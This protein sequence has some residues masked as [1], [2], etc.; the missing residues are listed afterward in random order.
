MHELIAIGYWREEEG[1]GASFPEPQML[2]TDAY[3]PATREAI[4]R[5]LDSGAVFMEYLGFSFCRFRC[6]IPDTA[7]GTADLSDGHWVWPQGLSHYVREHQLR[8]PEEFVQFMAD[9]DWMRPGPLSLPSLI[10]LPDGGTRIPVT[11]EF[12][13]QWSQA[14]RG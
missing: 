13:I 4:G 11:H 8:L 9:G 10:P 14:Q 3:S 2:K 6:G 1:S 12:W 7:L 5:Y